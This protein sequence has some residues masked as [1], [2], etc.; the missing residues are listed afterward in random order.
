MLQNYNINILYIPHYGDLHVD[1]KYISEASIIASRPLENINIKKIFSYETLSE[2]EWGMPYNHLRFK[3]NYFNVINKKHINKK[4]NAFKF[5]KS[6]IMSKNH[7]R[8]LN[9]I[10]LL[11]SYRGSIIGSEYCEAFN[12]IR[13]YE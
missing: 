9:S 6:Q 13:I 11:A 3:P 12:I 7:P 10:E 4:L 1:H 8:S 2:T 5:Y